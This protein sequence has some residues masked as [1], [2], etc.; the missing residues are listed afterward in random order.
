MGRKPKIDP[1]LQAWVELHQLSLGPAIEPAFQPQDDD[2]L[3]RTAAK[4]VFL[5]KKVKLLEVQVTTV[6]A[7]NEA[8]KREIKAIKKG[9]STPDR[10]PLWGL[11]ALAKKA[12]PVGRGQKLNHPKLAK[13][14]DNMKIVRERGLR[15]VCPPPWLELGIE[16]FPRTV[17]EALS[18]PVLKKRLRTLIS[19]AK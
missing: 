17:S 2:F 13:L 15:S 8:L 19:Q 9:K 10:C 6:E 1:E 12:L 16:P 14:V 7:Q 11:F 3:M 4:R 18:N 5:P